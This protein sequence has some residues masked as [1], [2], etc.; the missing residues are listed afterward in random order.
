MKAITAL[1]L[2]V[3]PATVFGTLDSAIK[4]NS[5][6]VAGLCTCLH[7]YAGQRK[8]LLWNMFGPEHDQR[9]LSECRRQKR[10][11]ASQYVPLPL[12]RSECE[13]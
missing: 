13:T 4:V 9:R 1:A 5:H 12:R 6:H 3:I 8:A 11:R 2:A 7:L 10:V